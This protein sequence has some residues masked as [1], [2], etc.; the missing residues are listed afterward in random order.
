MKYIDKFLKFLKTDRYTFLTFILTLFSIYV[1]VDRLVELV[2]LF[3]SGISVSYWNPIQ[4]TLALACPIFA[5]LFSGAS[6]YAD[7]RKTKVTLFYTYYIALYIVGVSMFVQCI[8][9][10]LW[11]L[12]LSVPN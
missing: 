6:K 7:S 3:F 2:F 4:Y 1:L 12:L 10:I 8:N 5:F 11:L 9:Y